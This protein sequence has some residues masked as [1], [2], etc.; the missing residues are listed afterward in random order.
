[1]RPLDLAA[2]GRGVDPRPAVVLRQPPRPR[3]RT[4]HCERNPCT[5]AAA[6]A[7]GRTI[8]SRRPAPS[9]VHWRAAWPAL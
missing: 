2:G 7:A 3:C 1:M 4:D 9:R 5:R 8:E 6:P